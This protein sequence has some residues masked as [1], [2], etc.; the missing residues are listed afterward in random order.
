[1]TS[2]RIADTANTSGT[3]IPAQAAAGIRRQIALMEAAQ[4][5]AEREGGLN[6]QQ[7]QFIVRLLETNHS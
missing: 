6:S 7:Q 2:Q 1:M 5:A 3:R 4:V